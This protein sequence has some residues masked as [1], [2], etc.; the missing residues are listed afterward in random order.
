MN[1]GVLEAGKGARRTTLER[2]EASF[3]MTSLEIG[4][5]VI[6]ARPPKGVVVWRRK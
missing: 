5:T 3:Q 6:M 2:R 1:L 4:E